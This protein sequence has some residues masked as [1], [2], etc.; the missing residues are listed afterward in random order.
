R[1]VLNHVVAVPG[2]V[3][4]LRGAAWRAAT[5]HYLMQ[6][7]NLRFL[8]L[9]HPGYLDALFDAEELAELAEKWANLT[10]IS[11]WADGAC[12]EPARRLI[13]NFPQAHHVPKGLWLTEGIVTVPW[14]SAHPIALLSGFFEFE[15]DEKTLHLAHE[16]KKDA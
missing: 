8:S 14:H 5:R 10:L 16:L 11:S 6:A 3:A 15:D 9:W 7:R 4:G 2:S 13:Q 12:A 1:K